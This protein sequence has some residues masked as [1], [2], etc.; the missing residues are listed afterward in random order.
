MIVAKE[1]NM[2][3]NTFI[4]VGAFGGAAIGVMGGLLGAYFGIKNTN[5]PRERAFVVRA[6]FLLC[7]VIAAFMA[8]LW[9]I[10]APYNALTWLPYMIG[11]LLIGRAWNRRQARIRMEEDEA[12]L[13]EG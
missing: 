13:R 6:T 3:Q 5:G 1:G 10:P 4:L 11:L 8:A 9:L 7:L 2:N 12:R